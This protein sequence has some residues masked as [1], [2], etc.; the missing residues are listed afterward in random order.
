MLYSLL[1]PIPTTLMSSAWQS[2]KEPF[3][4][5]DWELQWIH[6]LLHEAGLQEHLTRYH[7][8]NG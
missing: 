8:C 4:R 6:L 3:L 2:R 7:K 5:M 1:L